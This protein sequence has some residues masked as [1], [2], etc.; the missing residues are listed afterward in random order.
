[1]ASIRVAFPAL[2]LP[3]FLNRSTNHCNSLTSN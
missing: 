2:P 1:V 3:R